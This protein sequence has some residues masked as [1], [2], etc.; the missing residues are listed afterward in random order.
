[1]PPPFPISTDTRIFIAGHRG[2]VGSALCRHFTAR[3][4]RNLIG[5]TSKELDLRDEH[6]TTAFFTDNLW[7]QLN[8]LNSAVASGIERFLFFGSSCIYPKFAEQPISENALFNG[9]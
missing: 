8:L 9:P 4:F 7:I 2:L 3:G 1:M 5:R 6:A